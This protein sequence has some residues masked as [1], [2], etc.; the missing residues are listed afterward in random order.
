MGRQIRFR[1][2]PGDIVEFESL[3]RDSGGLFLPF[4]NPSSSPAPVRSTADIADWPRWKAWLVR[5]SD[6]PAVQMHHVPAQGFWTIDD[7][8]APVV[9]YG[10]HWHSLGPLRGPLTP[11]LL[12]SVGVREGRLWFERFYFEGDRKVE[13]P[14]DFVA[15][16]DALLQ[17][18][19]RRFHRHP[20]HDLY[21]GPDAM[22]L[23]SG[24]EGSG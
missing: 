11:E 14:A 9:E 21:E 12:R 1:V 4:R 7:L 2:G 15:W 17:T 24:A 5:P 22:R 8:G 18:V 3:V 16:A 6:A 10:F 20:G 19:R 13:K 23:I